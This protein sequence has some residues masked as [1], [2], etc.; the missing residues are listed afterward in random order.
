AADRAFRWFLGE[1][2]LGICMYDPKT[3]GCYD[4]L[5]SDNVNRNMGA[6]STLSWLYALTLM[7]AVQKHKNEIFYIDANQFQKNNVLLNL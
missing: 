5:M 3:H 1:N 2:D 6:E 4:G 7:H